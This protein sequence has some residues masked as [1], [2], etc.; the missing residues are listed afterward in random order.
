[1]KRCP[2]LVAARL[3]VR[4][5]I[6]FRRSCRPVKTLYLQGF[7]AHFSDLF[8]PLGGKIIFI[9]LVSFIVDRLLLV[10]FID[11]IYLLFSRWGVARKKVMYY[12]YSFILF[13][14]L[15]YLFIILPR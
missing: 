14:S 15:Y 6:C 12:I 10:Y 9:L 5:F 7:L 1:M 2:L 13:Y 8:A 11:I 4:P 3:P